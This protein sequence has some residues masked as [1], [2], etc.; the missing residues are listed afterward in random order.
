[1]VVTLDIGDFSNIHPANKK[2]VGNRLARLALV[3]QYDS[4]LNPLGPILSSS[5]MEKSNVELEFEH[6]G[7]GLI[8]KESKVNHTKK[9]YKSMLHTE[10]NKSWL[11]YIKKITIFRFKH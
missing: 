6:V 11:G 2:E 5:S 4:D 10:R 8:L 7:S 9:S 3:N 1:M